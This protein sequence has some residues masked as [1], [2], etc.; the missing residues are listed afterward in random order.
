VR[1]AILAW[2]DPAAG[3]LTEAIWPMADGTTKEVWRPD[4][5]ALVVDDDRIMIAL[6]GTSSVGATDAV[7]WAF[8]EHAR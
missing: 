7:G 8:L 6:A 2:G 4:H 5:V 1:D 3:P